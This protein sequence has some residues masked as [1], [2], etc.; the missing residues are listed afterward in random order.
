MKANKIGADCLEEFSAPHGVLSARRELLTVQQVEFIADETRRQSVDISMR[1]EKRGKQN[2]VIE[3]VVEAEELMKVTGSGVTLSRLKLKRSQSPVRAEEIA[4]RHLEPDPDSLIFVTGDRHR[5]APVGRH[6]NGNGREG[7]AGIP[8]ADLA[9]PG[10]DAGIFPELRELRSGT[11]EREVKRLDGAQRWRGATSTAPRLDQ[12]GTAVR[13]AT[14]FADV[15]AGHFV[16]VWASPADERLIQ[17]NAASIAIEVLIDLR[18]QPAGVVQMT[19]EGRNV[20][21]IV[22][23]RHRARELIENDVCRLERS[24][25]L[26]AEA[27]GDFRFGLLELIGLEDNI[28]LVIVAAGYVDRFSA[29]QRMVSTANI[30]RQIRTGKVPEMQVAVRCRGS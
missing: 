7:A 18:K 29:T 30:G 21:L 23:R 25:H 26:I 3:P 14:G 17:V 13:Q 27:T 28:A 16:A 20:P 2:C 11:P 1:N 22:H 12:I 19:E 5:N 4:R 24:I 9:K 6:S 15:A 10:A 8:V